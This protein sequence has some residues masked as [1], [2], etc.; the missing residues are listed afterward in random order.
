M[1]TSTQGKEGAEDSPNLEK[2]KRVK[3]TRQKR[4][5]QEPAGDCFL[6]KVLLED[7]RE[8]TRNLSQKGT[9]Q[10]VYDRVGW[11]GDCPRVFYIVS[12]WI[13]FFSDAKL[14]N[15][16]LLQ[17]E[18]LCL[19]TRKQNEITE[20]FGKDDE[21]SFYGNF[22]P[23]QSLDST[24]PYNKDKG[25]HRDKVEENKT[26]SEEPEK[27]KKKKTRKRRKKKKY[28]ISARRQQRN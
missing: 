4:L 17:S 26:L 13:R 27:K 28:C 23:N 25:E 16:N 8:I 18:K 19:I 6:I 14:L 24:I 3:A 15:N 12:I 2:I 7:N 22:D 9:Y 20:I 1:G 10:E 11:A 21:V 5:T